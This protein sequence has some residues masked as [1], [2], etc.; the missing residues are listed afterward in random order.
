MRSKEERNQI[1]RTMF[2]RVM[3][4]GDGGDCAITAGPGSGRSVAELIGTQASGK[5][6]RSLAAKA[7]LDGVWSFRSVATHA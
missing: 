4:L 3:L 7:I 5:A 1:R 2:R 6:E